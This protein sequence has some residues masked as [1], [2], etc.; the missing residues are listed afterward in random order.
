MA[1]ILTEKC[2]LRAF[3]ASWKYSR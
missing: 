3:T 2:N 1:V